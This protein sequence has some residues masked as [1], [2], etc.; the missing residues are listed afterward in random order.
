M[1]KSAKEAEEKLRQEVGHTIA[2]YVH[3]E[4]GMIYCRGVDRSKDIAEELGTQPLHSTTEKEAFAR[5]WETFVEDPETKLCVSTCVIGVGVD[6]PHVRNVWH[7][8][9]P[10]SLVDYAQETGRCG[11]DGKPATC[12][13]IT[14]Q[15]ELKRQG[16]SES[17]PQHTEDD[18]RRMASAVDECRRVRM[19]AVLDE[20]QVSCTMLTDANLCDNCRRASMD[21]KS[22]QPEPQPRAPQD[23]SLPEQSPSSRDSL[24][25]MDDMPPTPD[26]GDWTGNPPGT[27]RRT[28]PKNQKED[29]YA[30]Y[31]WALRR[32]TASAD[33]ENPNA[34]GC[35]SRS[36]SLSPSTTPNSSLSKRKSPPEGQK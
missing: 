4:K 26:P 18:L 9:L 16:H 33:F 12:H 27:K 28:E 15:S 24:Y 19:G 29:G 20:R 21:D 8:G 13:L 11:R 25:S 6:V 5:T 30:P 14:W 36:T 32:L 17:G 7:Y 2:S 1:C 22:P 3:G 34:R 23:F 10:W 31:V 35:F